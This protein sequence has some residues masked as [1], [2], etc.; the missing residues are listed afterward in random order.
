MTYRTRVWLTGL[1]N[2]VITGGLSSVPIV[3]IDP[4]D[5]NPLQGG[6]GKLAMAASATALLA[7]WMYMKD[8][9]IP[10]PEKDVDAQAAAKTIVQAVTEKTDSYTADEVARGLTID[11]RNRLDGR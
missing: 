3:I 8:H 11:P 7:L 1:L 4:E 6:L 10:D 9:P 5:F 2:A